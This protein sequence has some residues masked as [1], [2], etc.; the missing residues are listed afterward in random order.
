MKKSKAEVQT[1]DVQTLIQIDQDEG[2]WTGSVGWGGFHEGVDWANHFKIHLGSREATSWSSGSIK[3]K[4]HIVLMGSMT[5]VWRKVLSVESRCTRKRVMDGIARARYLDSGWT[6]CS[7]RQSS[8][9]LDLGA[10]SRLWDTSM[11]SSR[12]PTGSSIRFW[13]FDPNSG[14]HSLG[15]T[16]HYTKPKL[17]NQGK[18]FT[19]RSV[20]R[21][22]EKGERIW[23]RR[24]AKM[25]CADL[26]EN[27]SHRLRCLSPWS[28]AGG[29]V[30]GKC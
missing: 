29:A 20:Y 28:A 1:Q 14:P 5:G 6:Q 13:W 2:S 3:S 22:R 10:S 7:W 30:W 23:G 24:G 12:V 25:H 17:V 27:V 9:V 15:G 21:I 8:V 26:N 11:A 16:G 18:G 19:G 4:G